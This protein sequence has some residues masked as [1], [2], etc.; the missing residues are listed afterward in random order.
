MQKAVSKPD[1]VAALVSLLTSDRSETQVLCIRCLARFAA[2]TDAP[3][4]AYCT[5]DVA[6][7]FIQSCLV[8]SPCLVCAYNNKQHTVVSSTGRL[9]GRSARRHASICAWC[10]GQGIQFTYSLLCRPGLYHTH[11]MVLV[12]ASRM[13]TCTPNLLANTLCLVKVVSNTRT[14]LAVAE[15]SCCRH[16]ARS[17]WRAA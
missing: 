12:P 17:L 15:Q 10:S 16:P 4:Q 6:E 13:H 5:A 1:I 3:R 2:W 14:R 11:C 7:V 8:C 9:E